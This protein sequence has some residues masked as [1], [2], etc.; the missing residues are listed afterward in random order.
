[1]AL[2]VRRM[3]P[4][5][6]HN[7]SWQKVQD[8]AQLEHKLLVQHNVVCND[9]A[10]PLHPLHPF[11]L[12]RLREELEARDESSANCCF[13]SKNRC[14]ICLWRLW[15]CDDLRITTIDLYIDLGP[16]MIHTC[17]CWLE[18][19]LEVLWSLVATTWSELRED[20]LPWPS[21]GSCW[22]FLGLSTL[23]GSGC[24]C[25]RLWRPGKW[26]ASPKLTWTQFWH[27]FYLEKSLNCRLLHLEKSL[28]VPLKVFFFRKVWLSKWRQVISRAFHL[29]CMSFHLY[30]KE[31][32][33]IQITVNEESIWF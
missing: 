5:S 28:T 7:Q 9:W 20:L 22:Y 19:R 16:T 10:S 18:V 3:S 21:A 26:K 17:P 27:K 13:F 30:L 25:K 29:I 1:M 33:M 2:L 11:G 6:W 8:L 4:Q 12:I 32:K 23:L 15:S 31:A 14:H 24:H